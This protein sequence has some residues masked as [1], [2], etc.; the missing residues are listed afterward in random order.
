M[1]DV[2]ISKIPVYSASDMEMILGQASIVGQASINELGVISIT[3]D[4]AK[5]HT[6]KH[7]FVRNQV[8]AFT[9]GLNY[10]PNL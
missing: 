5:M 1:D 8:V 3:S 4:L 2:S 7:Q 9:L 10:N 6:T